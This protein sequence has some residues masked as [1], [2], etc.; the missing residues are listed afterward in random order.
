MRL[1]R[2]EGAVVDGCGSVGRNGLG[3]DFGAHRR[4]RPVAELTQAVFRH[5]QDVF[6]ATA[7][8]ACGLQVI[9]QRGQ[10]IGQVIHLRPAGHAMIL[11]QFVID[12]ATH[13]LRQFGRPR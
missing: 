9:L 13:A 11:Q 3:L 8:L 7:M 1:G 4:H 12:E 2:G 5:V 6:Q 10:C